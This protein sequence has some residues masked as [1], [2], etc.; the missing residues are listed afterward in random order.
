MEDFPHTILVSGS[1]QVDEPEAPMMTRADAWTAVLI[2]GLSVGLVVAA[3]LG[4]VHLLKV[5]T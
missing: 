3:F 5:N 4:L 1:E 2:F